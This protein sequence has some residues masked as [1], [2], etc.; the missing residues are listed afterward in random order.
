MQIVSLADDEDIKPSSLLSDAIWTYRICRLFSIS[1]SVQTVT[2][3]DDRK[4][5]ADL[6]V[7]ILR[8]R[9]K[10]LMKRHIERIQAYSLG[11]SACI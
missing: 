6:L 8:G 3:T 4:D 5:K 7:K 11:T 1:Y 10:I 9:I 2:V